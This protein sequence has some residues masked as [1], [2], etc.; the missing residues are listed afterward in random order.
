MSRIGIALAGGGPLGGIYEVG[1]CV[2]L[3]EAI[4]GLD[5]ARADV[6]VGV[7]AGSFVAALLANGFEPR[8]LARILLASDRD[9]GFDPSRLLRPALG[10]YARRLWTVPRLAAEGVLQYLGRSRGLFESLQRLSRAI[11]SGVFDGAGIDAVLRQLFSE[12]G[13]T[14]DFRQLRGKLFVIATD[15]D[16]S[17]AVVFGAP[18]RDAVPISTAVQASAALPGLFPPV[19]IDGRHYV[20]GALIKTLHASVALRD[21]VDLL[22]CINPL[23]PFDATLAEQ[24]DGR[25]HRL[26]DGGLPA[27]LGQTFRAIIRSR[28]RVGMERY[29][30][31]FKNADVVVF[32]PGQ[33][34]E[35]IFL[36]N[37][38]SYGDR[39]RL[40]EHA[41][42]RTRAD[43]YQRRDELAPLLQRHG[44]ALNLDVLRDGRRTLLE[45]GQVPVPATMA[46][47]VSALERA[48]DELQDRVRPAPAA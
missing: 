15:L 42:Q 17:Q 30:H 31:E 36:A 33:D 9:L 43:L 25:R 3:E 26:Y 40:C 20:D 48:L 6:Y 45:P 47:S 7:S 24:R 35:V 21:G 28:M 2:A 46:A 4:D 39:T 34:D 44:L 37:L 13:H 1:A 38:F 18:G 23:V 22:L 19:E 27:V 12:A 14:N 10:E 16:S 11:P 29:R 32:E 8:R 41:Y 5:A